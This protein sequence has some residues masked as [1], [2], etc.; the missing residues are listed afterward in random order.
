MNVCMCKY[1]SYSVNSYLSLHAHANK[2]TD[3]IIL[4]APYIH[5]SENGIHDFL[6]SFSII[7][8]FLDFAIEQ[9]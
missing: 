8:L 2:Q 7:V 1:L 9:F 4:Y 3:N 5:T 6:M